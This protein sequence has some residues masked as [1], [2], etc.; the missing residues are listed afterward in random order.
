MR[1]VTEILN[2]EDHTGESR[3]WLDEQI[4]RITEERDLT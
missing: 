1:H 4:G 3:A 2:G